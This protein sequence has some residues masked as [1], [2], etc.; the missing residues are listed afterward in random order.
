MKLTNKLWKLQNTLE[1]WNYSKSFE[2][3][4][5]LPVFHKKNNTSHNWS[6]KT[7]NLV[8]ASFAMTISL[9]LGCIFTAVRMH[10]YLL[11]NVMRL[12]LW[13]FDSTPIGRILN[14]FSMD[15]EVVD[16]TLPQ[17]LRSWIQ[18]FFGVNPHFF[19]TC[20]GSRSLFHLYRPDF[21]GIAIAL[22]FSL[23]IL[24]S[25]IFTARDINFTMIGIIKCGEWGNIKVTVPLLIICFIVANATLRLRVG[26]LFWKRFKTVA[27]TCRCGWDEGCKAINELPSLKRVIPCAAFN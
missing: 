19:A 26:I 11:T 13:F 15:V 22:C 7:P 12:P 23:N 5:K 17:N 18:Q 27:L 2:S 25:S 1:A 4:V 21:H 14:R 8:I 3:S 9:A 10:V 16:T 6:S 20:R 24:F